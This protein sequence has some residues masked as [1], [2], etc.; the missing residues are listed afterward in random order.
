MLCLPLHSPHKQDGLL[1]SE[2]TN[3]A[4][5]SP[6]GGQRR[7]CWFT[8]ALF[9]I[10]LFTLSCTSHNFSNQ[11]VWL[12]QFA[13]SAF[14]LWLCFPLWSGAPGSFATGRVADWEPVAGGAALKV[15]IIFT[16][17]RFSILQIRYGPLPS[18]LFWNI[19]FKFLNLTH[20]DSDS[21]DSS[22][23]PVQVK[24]TSI[25]VL[26]VFTKIAWSF[27][28]SNAIWAWRRALEK[29]REL[30]HPEIVGFI[31]KTNFLE[32]WWNM[33]NELSSKDCKLFLWTTAF[34]GGKCY[35][36]NKFSPNCVFAW[37]APLDTLNNFMKDHFA[38]KHYYIFI[39]IP[40]TQNDNTI[41][42]KLLLIL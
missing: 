34:K 18:M 31:S 37:S 6:G 35:F 14:R 7:R 9:I 5:P 24:K 36:V 15:N 2:P 42:I 26:D 13:R 38:A 16:M 28:G 12:D 27:A 39:F 23:R 29:K 19:K 25:S 20:R 4:A 40:T 1:W 17:Q 3:G 30:W 8:P 32:I 41:Q 10:S 21:E 33:S 22:D 11:N